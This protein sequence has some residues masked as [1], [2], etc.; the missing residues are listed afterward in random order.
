MA[1]GSTREKGPRRGRRG[2]AGLR[3]YAIAVVTAAVVATVLIV[4]LVLSLGDDGDGGGAADGPVV[5][6]SPRP[7]DIAREG[8]LLGSAGAPVTVIEYGDFQ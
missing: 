1:A 8:H 6:P 2:Q 4:V 3:P 7:T 5:V